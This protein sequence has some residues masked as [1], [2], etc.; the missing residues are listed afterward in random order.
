ML[1]WTVLVEITQVE[2]RCIGSTKRVSSLI[3]RTSN[4][5][6]KDV[7]PCKAI[8]GAKP[9]AKFPIFLKFFTR[10]SPAKKR[11]L[12]SE[13]F[14]PSDC[15]SRA[16]ASSN[17]MRTSRRS[18]S[19]TRAESRINRWVSPQAGFFPYGVRIQREI[20]AWLRRHRRGRSGTSL[21]GRRLL[22]HGT[23]LN[24]FGGNRRRR[25]ITRSRKRFGIC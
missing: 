4:E 21:I 19:A 18:E 14:R 1:C 17:P 3:G 25:G 9:L 13:A 16:S 23:A 11:R 8:F 10:F 15:S 20:A 7:S 12:I 24:R 22:R 6:A 2:S 5:A